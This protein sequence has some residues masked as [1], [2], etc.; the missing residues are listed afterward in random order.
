M[1]QTLKLQVVGD[2]DST[3][4]T[5]IFFVT[6]MQQMNV[7]KITSI[8]LLSLLSLVALQIPFTELL[9]ANVR[10]TAFDFIAPT[11]G[12]FLGTFPG[13]IA[14]LTAQVL[15][16]L[17]HG[18]T[19]DVASIVRLLPMLFA[20][21]YFAKKRTI[22]VIIPILAIIAF[23]ANPTGR[24]AWQY[25][26]FWLIPI[27]ANFYRKNLFVKSLGATF[28]AHAVGGAIWVWTFGLTK[29]MWL[30]LIP[31][32][33]V[34]RIAMAC[35]ITAFYLIFSKVLNYASKTKLSSLLSFTTKSS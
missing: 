30:S 26:L 1:E 14:V 34:E 35:G 31:V 8:F 7:K 11:L 10:F 20:V 17:I 23:N 22:N 13:V 28:T 6:M 24:E 4:D 3:V 29:E 5:N 15:N 32:V 33:A 25:S 2:Q 18:T 12:A 27:A 21:I 9:G 16:A 19:T